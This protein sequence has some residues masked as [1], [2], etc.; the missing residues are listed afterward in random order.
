M[1]NAAMTRRS[2]RHVWHPC[3]QMKLHEA[4]PPVPI[5]RAEGVWLATGGEIIDAYR[6]VKAGEAGS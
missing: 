4:H 3:T 6:K 1:D 2:L 5:A